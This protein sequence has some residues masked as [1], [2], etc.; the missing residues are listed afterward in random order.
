MNKAIRFA[1]MLVPA[2]ILAGLVTNTIM[3]QDAAKI[4]PFSYTASPEVYKLLAENEQFRVILQTSKPGQRDAFHS[5]FAAAVYRLG[6]C[7]ARIYSPDGKPGNTVTRKAGEASLQSA[8]ASHSFEN[9][10]K[11][12]CVAVI[13][14]RK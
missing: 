7:T 3:A 1:G 5:H 10:G 9:T 8:V 11:T 4:A 6:D 13:V 12:D 14:E 2:F